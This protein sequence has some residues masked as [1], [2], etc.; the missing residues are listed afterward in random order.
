VRITVAEL[1]AGQLPTVFAAAFAEALMTLLLE[2]NSAAEPADMVRFETRGAYLAQFVTDV[3]AGVAAGRWEYEE[4]G[5]LSGKDAVDAI[6]NLFEREPLQFLPVLRELER[7]STLEPVLGRLGEY[8][9]ERLLIA[10]ASIWPYT[11]QEIS[12]ADLIR[13]AQAVLALESSSARFPGARR[14]HALRI[15]LHNAADTAAG[16]QRLSPRQA[17]ICLK[18]L[19]F[20]LRHLAG[21]TVEDW[22]RRL[23]ELPNEAGS[24][25]VTLCD[26]D[27]ISN[28]RYAAGSAERAVLGELLEKLARTSPAAPAAVAEQVISSKCVGLFFLI[29]YLLRDNWPAIVLQCEGEPATAARELQLLL[30]LLSLESLGPSEEGMGEIDPGLKLFSGW[31]GLPDLPALWNFRSTR[32]PILC[33]EL[34]L[35]LAPR[36]EFPAEETETCESSVA[37]LARR[38]VQQM[39]QDIPGLRQASREFLVKNTLALPGRIRITRELLTVELPPAPF[40]VALHIAGLDQ[41]VAA[42]PWLGS[43]GIRFVLE[44]L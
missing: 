20:S 3:L 43:R 21:T 37:W 32:A 13:V 44:G 18:I 2:G 8:G 22:T 23:N 40:Q 30:S 42:V 4:L 17:F 26:S 34:R 11:N 1:E 14:A 9:I 16:A 10:T 28:L 29:R 24:D 39:R 36:S 7:H 31:F 12:V 35:R 27:V 19:E 25:P 41:T 33:R 38:Y 6:V 15:Y 5:E